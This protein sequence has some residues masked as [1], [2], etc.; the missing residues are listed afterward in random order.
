MFLGFLD[1]GKHK[2]PV[3]GLGTIPFLSPQKYPCVVFWLTI[4]TLE[5]YL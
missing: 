4:R 2:K 3:T 1:F 5:H